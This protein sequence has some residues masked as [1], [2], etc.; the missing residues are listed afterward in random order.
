MSA[1]PAKQTKVSRIVDGSVGVH[2]AD[3]VHASE[4]VVALVLKFWCNRESFSFTG[5]HKRN[6]EC[7]PMLML[8]DNNDSWDNRLEN[9]VPTVISFDDYAG[10]EIFSMNNHVFH[11]LRIC[12]IKPQA[13]PQQ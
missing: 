12:L 2:G 5:I 1:E 7:P 9:P 3:I 6:A 4:S 10:W 8:K 13:Q 11:G